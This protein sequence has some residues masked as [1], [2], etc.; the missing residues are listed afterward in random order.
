MSKQHP[1]VVYIGDNCE[2]IEPHVFYMYTIEEAVEVLPI[3]GMN[4]P[5]ALIINQ[6]HPL[7]SEILHL[8]NGSRWHGPEVILITRYPSQ[9]RENATCVQSESEAIEVLM[10]WLQNKE[11]SEA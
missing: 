10:H 7:A 8:I 9:V 4:M 2:A 6:N 1:L 3:L 11:P 5:D